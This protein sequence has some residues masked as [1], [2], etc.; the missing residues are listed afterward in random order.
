MDL[1]WWGVVIAGMALLAGCIGAAMLSPDR[2]GRRELR[3][4]AHVDRLTRLPE[5]VRALRR[6]MLSVIVVIFLL[7][8]GFTAALWTTARPAGLPNIASASAAGQPEDIMV[9]VGESAATPAVAQTLEY[10]AQR[11]GGFGTTRVGL[12]S[13]NVRVVPLTR[14]HQ[15]AAARFTAYAHSADPGAAPA[16]FVAPVRYADY[17]ATVEDVLALCL[18]GFPEFDEPAGQRRSLVYVGPGTLGENRGTPS[19]FSAEQVRELATTAGIQVNVVYTGPPSA[20]LDALARDTGGQTASA[21]SEVAT[22][23]AAIRN[24][25]PEPAAVDDVGATVG[26]ETPDVPLLM[27]LLAVLALAWWPVVRRS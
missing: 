14:D 23:L 21:G 5:Y 4:L 1:M 17:A 10:F 25:P 15:H 16:A 8:V 12:T 18:T 24:H 20:E 22:Q 6:R 9:C 13:A 19:L 11:V 3:P 27:A 26:V 2:A 7:A